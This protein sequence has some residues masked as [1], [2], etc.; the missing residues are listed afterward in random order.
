MNAR[1][2]PL[3]GFDQQVQDISVE[4]ADVVG[5]YRSAHD[6][7]GRGNDANTEEMRQA[8]IHC[9]VVF[10]AILGGVPVS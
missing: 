10:S 7:A 6:I 3:T 5:N 8:M 1:G 2:Y 4:H 9:R